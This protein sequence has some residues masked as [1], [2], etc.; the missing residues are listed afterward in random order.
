[1]NIAK[2]ID[3]LTWFNLIEKLKKILK[4]INGNLFP[5]AP[6]DGNQYGM[7]DGEWTQIISSE[8]GLESL[9]GDFVDNTDPLN[10]VLD[11]GYKV[12]S[13]IVNQS[14]ASN[15]P[16]FAVLENTLGLALTPLYSNAGDYLFTP[17]IDLPLDKTIM[18]LGTVKPTANTSTTKYHYTI[19]QSVTNLFNI[20]TFQAGTSTW[21]QTDNCLWNNYG[22]WECL[23]I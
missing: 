2:L 6:E 7:Q 1:M 22:C 23:F 21:S 11:R 9:S 17:N 12:Y 15:V 18:F 3:Q 4:G 10:P 5:L 8:G 20:K 16:I 13:A 14:G 19:I